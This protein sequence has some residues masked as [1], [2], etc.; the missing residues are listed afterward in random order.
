MISIIELQIAS[1]ILIK[2][3][4]LH[5][6]WNHQSVYN[7]ATGMSASVHVTQPAGDVRRTLDLFITSL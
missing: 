4:D 6:S 7:I 1:E 2:T 3:N 5:M